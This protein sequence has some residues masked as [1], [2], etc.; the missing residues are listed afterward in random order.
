MFDPNKRNGVQNIGTTNTGIQL[1]MRDPHIKTRAKQIEAVQN[2]AARFVSGIYKRKSSITTIKQE[3]KWSELETRRKVIRWIIFHQNPVRQLAIPVQWVHNFLRLVQ[4]TSRH[5][6]P[7]LNFTSIAANKN[8]YKNS[9]LPHTLV[10]WNNLPHSADTV[11]H[12]N[13]RQGQGSLNVCIKPPFQHQLRTSKLRTPNPACVT[14]IRGRWAVYHKKKEDLQN[15]HQNTWIRPSLG[16]FPRPGVTIN[17][18]SNP[19]H[20]SN[21]CNHR[22]RDPWLQLFCGVTLTFKLSQVWCQKSFR[23]MEKKNQNII[24]LTCRASLEY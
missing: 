19:N 13:P 15:T 22:C 1:T 24:L 21:D 16:R 12:F 3:L 6:N 5:T 2:R 20:S 14:S 17:E 7:E 9:F 18:M 8:C 23:L 4:R 11:N 10:D